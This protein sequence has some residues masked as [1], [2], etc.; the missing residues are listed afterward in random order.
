MVLDALCE[1]LRFDEASHTY[2]TEAGRVPSVTQIISPLSERIYGK[3]PADVLSAAANRGRT[4]H[5]AIE[6]YKAT[7][8]EDVPDAFSGYFKAFREFD[9]AYKPRVVATEQPFFCRTYGYAGTVDMICII[10]GRCVLVDFKTTADL[11]EEIAGLQVEAYKRGVKDVCK[12]DDLMILQL[13]KDGTYRVRMLPEE[14]A[15]E[16]WQIFLSLLAIENYARKM[17]A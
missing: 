2:K 12:I 6:F 14:K 13:K 11:H 8:F 1:G 15:S 7:G 17:V 3:I 16:R 9:D 4:I 10:N 5:Q